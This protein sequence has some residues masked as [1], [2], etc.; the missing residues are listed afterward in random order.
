MWH[1]FMVEHHIKARL[2]KFGMV[3][4]SLLGPQGISKTICKV[5][6]LTFQSYAMLCLM[7]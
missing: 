2:I 5:T 7:K 4:T 3:L 1:V 6:V